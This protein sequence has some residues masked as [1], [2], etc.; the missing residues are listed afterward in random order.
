[1][2]H[3]KGLV[4]MVPAKVLKTVYLV[5]HGQS[6]GNVGESFQGIDSPLTEQGYAQA[7]L[8]AQR[9]SEIPFEALISTT[10]PRAKATAEAIERA[11]GKA[12]EFS[13]LFVERIKP[14]GLAGK[15][16]TDPEAHEIWK[17]WNQSLYTSGERVSDGENFDDIVERSDSALEFLSDRPEQ[18]LVVVTHGYFLRALVARVMLMNQLTGP[19]FRSFQQ[20]AIT[21]NTGI[22]VLRYTE[23]YEGVG[24]TLWT[25]NDHAHLG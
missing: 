2:A 24:W 8:V 4:P 16:L 12:A 20:H 1:M 10:L 21:E 9:I 7:E 17:K 14:T 13:P 18:S 11:T 6:E 19:T 5:R 15:P 22:T 25:F 3:Q 23:R